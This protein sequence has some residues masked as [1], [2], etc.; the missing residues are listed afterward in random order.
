[1]QLSGGNTTYFIIKRSKIAP[2]G[3]SIETVKMA[4]FVSGVEIL[5]VLGVEVFTGGSTESN[6][7]SFQAFVTIYLTIYLKK[8][9]KKAK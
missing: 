7:R 5:Q 3:I 4:F 2:L 9:S 6:V 1:M 8:A